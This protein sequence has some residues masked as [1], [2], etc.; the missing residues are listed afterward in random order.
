MKKL[1]HYFMF[2][3]LFSIFLPIRS[4]FADNT[5]YKISYDITNFSVGSDGDTI[6]FEG[7][8]FLSHMDN[9]GGIN[10]DTYIAAYTGRWQSKWH[11]QRV[12]NDSRRCYSLKTDSSDGDLYFIRCT[13]TACSDSFRAG[14]VDDLE[15]SKKTFAFSECMGGKYTTKSPRITRSGSHCAYHRVGFKKD[16]KISKILKY[17]NNTENDIH[18]R[19]ITIAK[20]GKT[21]ND[22]NKGSVKVDDTDIGV[23]ANSCSS[24]FNQTCTKN[25]ENYKTTYYQNSTVG[26]IQIREKK[27]RTITV[28]GLDD[29]VIFTAVN[30]SGSWD[31]SYTNGRDQNFNPG[32]KY[33]IDAVTPFKVDWDNWKGDETGTVSGRLLKITGDPKSNSDDYGY[34]WSAWVKTSGALKL[35]IKDKTDTTCTGCSCANNAIVAC[36]GSNCTINS[37]TGCPNSTRVLSLKTQNGTADHSTC[38]SVNNLTV[39][40]SEQAEQVYWLNIPRSKIDE[41]LVN[42]GVKY[43]TY[44][45]YESGENITNKLVLDGNTYWFPIKLQA[46]VQ[47]TQTFNLNLNFVSSKVDSGGSFPFSFNYGTSVSS[48]AYPYDVSK[49]TSQYNTYQNTYEFKVIDSSGVTSDKNIAIGLTSGDEIFRSPSVQS[50]ITYTADLFNSIASNV[51]QKDLRDSGRYAKVTFPDTNKPSVSKEDAGDFTCASSSECSYILRQAYVSKDGS[52]KVQY[53]QTEVPGFDKLQSQG[54]RY[55]VSPTWKTGVPFEFKIEAKFG[56]PNTKFNY[57]ATCSLDTITNKIHSTKYV[58][59]RS[60]DTS[61]P[62]PD[63]SKIP[64]NWKEYQKVDSNFSRIVNTSFNDKAINYQT[65]FFGSSI[66]NTLKEL[67]NSNKIGSYSSY[68]D[69]T[70]SGSDKLITDTDIF[71]VKSVTSGQNYCFTGQFNENCNKLL[72]G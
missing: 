57:N 22:I 43:V 5:D 65:G 67:E 69:V 12:C 31:P 11:N 35:K 14:I 26:N 58:K 60:I 28:N 48:S 20:G 71:S 49:G 1:V 33:K 8:S 61:N 63:S 6:H 38:S 46:L 10:M 21:R 42:Q 66:K 27:E 53:S 45:E 25:K 37:S 36:V 7:W 17:L 2:I 62:F 72:V 55:I 52:G 30:A 56:L 44:A 24:I 13:D 23:I 39:S 59:Y 3:V 51:S 32:K 54:S 18:F 19:I 41:K 47:F 50:K 4:V 16:M 40:S 64:E 15:N 68:K 29:T 34:A 9:Y 70:S